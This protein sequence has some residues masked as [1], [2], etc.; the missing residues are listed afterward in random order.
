MLDELE[1]DDWERIIYVRDG[2]EMFSVTT[3]EHEDKIAGV[4]VIASRNPVHSVLFL[5]LAFFNA[6]G[7]FVHAYTLRAD[8]L[9]GGAG[10]FD[11]VVRFLAVEAGLDGVFTDHPDRVVAALRGSGT[12]SSSK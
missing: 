12:S 8:Q 5:I 3:K 2:D 1:R 6:A 10:S 7:L 4:M 11:D 9:P